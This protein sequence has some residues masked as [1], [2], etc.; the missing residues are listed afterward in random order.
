MKTVSIIV[1]LAASCLYFG[2]TPSLYLPANTDPMRQNT[3][4]E[5]RQLYVQH[6]SSCHNL[7]LPKQFSTAQW[8]ENLDEMQERAHLSEAQKACIMD[9]LNSQPEVRRRRPKH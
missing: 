6:C 5:G 4:L 2:C 9:Y 3:L 7:F 1:L 8:S